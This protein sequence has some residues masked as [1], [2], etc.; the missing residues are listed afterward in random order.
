[1]RSQTGRVV[2]EFVH[3][4]VRVV[5]P[6]DE[7]PF[8]AESTRRRGQPLLAGRVEAF[9]GV[10]AIERHEFITRV[11]VRRVQ[12]HRQREGQSLRGQSLDGGRDAHGGDG[13]VARRH[14][15]VLVQALDHCDSDWIVGERLTHPHEDDVGQPPRRGGACGVHDL[16]DDLT[17]TEL[18]RET[19]LAR[20]AERA[21][22]RATRLGGDAHGDA[23]G[24]AHQNR[25]DG[26][27][28]VQTKH[29]LARGAEIAGDLVGHFERR[30]KLVG[31]A[32]AQGLG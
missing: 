13:E 22:H 31:Q 8:E 21:A 11:V 16:L 30:R 7:R 18:A 6:V 12:A 10:T 23:I 32:L 15:A 20:G 19:R 29:P 2:G 14:G 28:V 1:V 17:D 3:R 26:G 25:L 24:V 4:L 27:A 5:H 9:E